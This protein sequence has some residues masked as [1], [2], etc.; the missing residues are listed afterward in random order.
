VQQTPS[1]VE[2]EGVTYQNKSW[3]LGLF[4][5][6]VGTEFQDNGAYH[7]QYTVNPFTLTNA[8]L[9]Y[10]VRSGR[11]ANTKF[12]MSFNNLLNEHS[13]TSVQLAGSPVAHTLS[14]NGIAYTDPFRTDGQTLI[15][16]QDNVSILPARSIMVSVTFGFS[17]KGMVSKMF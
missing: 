10:T 8:N 11:L 3:D 12:A 14:S 5:K 15:N 7:N 1:D 17:P 6:R 2:T 9:N 13:I 16:G 4:N